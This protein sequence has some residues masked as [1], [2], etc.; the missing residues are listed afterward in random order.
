MNELP[1]IWTAIGVEGLLLLILGTLAIMMPVIFSFG[2][3]VTIGGLLLISGIIKLFRTMKLEIGEHFWASLLLCAVEIA[4][5]LSILIY[6][7]RGLVFLT[8]LLIVYF[9]IAGID[10][11]MLAFNLKRHKGWLWI[12]ISGI[13]SLL[14]SFFLIYFWTGAVALTLGLLFGINM[15]LFGFALIFAWGTAFSV[16][17]V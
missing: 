8:A 4:L 16:E 15:I 1:K 3:V 9:I 7:G 2:V 10:K 12:L 11:I 5:G 17:E 6:P 13:I 14:F